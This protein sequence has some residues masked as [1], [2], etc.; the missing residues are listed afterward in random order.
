MRRVV[1]PLL[2]PTLLNSWLLHFLGAT[3]ALVIFLFIY[4]PASKVL[5]IDIFEKMIGSEAQQA[6]VLGVILTA[7]SMVVAI[8]AR[9]VARRQRRTMEVAAI[10]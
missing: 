5:S 6:T 7:I 1:L 8:F 2:A 4:Q 10:G 9:V 3:R